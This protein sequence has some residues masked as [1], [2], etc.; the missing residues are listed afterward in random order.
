VSTRTTLFI[1]RRSTRKGKCRRYPKMDAKKEKGPASSRREFLYNVFRKE[2]GGKQPAFCRKKKKGRKEKEKYSFCSSHPEL[3]NRKKRGETDITP[4]KREGIK[5]LGKRKGAY[6]C[7]ERCCIRRGLSE[8]GKEVI[9]VRQR[10]R[11]K[12][13]RDRYHSTF[14]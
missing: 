2:K 10:K 14:L 12:E 1:P 11:K 9:F 13:E 5:N 3:R 6:V 8:K 4:K 7:P